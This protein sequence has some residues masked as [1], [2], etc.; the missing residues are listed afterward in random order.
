MI[1]LESAENLLRKDAINYWEMSAELLRDINNMIDALYRIDNAGGF[2]GEEAVSS[3]S[4]FDKVIESQ[5][6]DACELINKLEI[7]RANIFGQIINW[8]VVQDILEKHEEEGAAKLAKD[9]AEYLTMFDDEE[10]RAVQ[11]WMMDGECPYILRKA[12]ARCYEKDEKPVD[13]IRV[14]RLSERTWELARSIPSPLF[15]VDPFR[16]GDE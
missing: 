16:T 1:N 8:D 12:M 14:N 3:S 13:G 2:N 7:I 10:K 11:K 6:I 9:M 15:A 5:K 4:I